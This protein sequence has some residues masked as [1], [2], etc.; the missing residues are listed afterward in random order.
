MVLVDDTACWAPRESPRNRDIELGRDEETSCN[1]R[2]KG[3]S[4]GEKQSTCS[5]DQ[6]PFENV[7]YLERR[8]VFEG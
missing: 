3:Y 7:K 2:Q 6:D 8:L 1:S 5:P 4:N